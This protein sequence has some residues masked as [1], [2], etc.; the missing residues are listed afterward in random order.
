MVFVGSFL[1]AVTAPSGYTHPVTGN[2]VDDLSFSII[3]WHMFLLIWKCYQKSFFLIMYTHPT[4]YRRCATMLG[5]KDLIRPLSALTQ[6]Y[7]T[8]KRHLATKECSC[9]TGLRLMKLLSPTVSAIVCQGAYML[10]IS[11]VLSSPCAPPF[12]P[13]ASLH[14]YMC[15]G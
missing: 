2:L 1:G 10:Q 12:L 15:R 6:R 7:F 5:L 8:T 14:G 13:E 3:F 11:S 9:W 4:K